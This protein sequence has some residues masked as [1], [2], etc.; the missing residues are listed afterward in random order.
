MTDLDSAPSGGGVELP[1]PTKSADAGARAVLAEEG[2]D[3]L[4]IVALIV[5]VVLAGLL[6]FAFSGSLSSAIAQ[7]EESPCRALEPELR[8]GQVIPLSAKD[9]EGNDVTLSQLEGKFVVLNFWATWCEPCTREWPE[10]DKLARRLE[11]RDDVV[12]V[13]VSLDQDPGLIRPYLARMGLSDTPVQVWSDATADG[14][15]AFGGEKLP[16][17]YFIDEA[18]RYVMAFI[19]V[20]RWGMPAGA[21]CVESRVGLR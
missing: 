8:P 18:G 5:F 6:L 16:D 17:T 3:G 14:N 10:L 1:P 9:L 7:Q 20:R 19:N 2:P 21:R 13:A 11:G 12:I 15:R 4:G